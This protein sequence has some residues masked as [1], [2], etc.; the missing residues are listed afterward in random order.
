MNAA[1]T[2]AASPAVARQVAAVAE[3]FTRNRPTDRMTDA[4]LMTVALVAVDGSAQAVRPLLRVLPF[5]AGDIT[6]GEYALHIHKTAWA[7]GHTSTPS[8]RFAL[9]G[10][11]R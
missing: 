7:L 8:P 4:A 10:G 5:A 11:T 3:H 2:L 1:H 9:A 6:R